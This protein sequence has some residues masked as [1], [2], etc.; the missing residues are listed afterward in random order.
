MSKTERVGRAAATECG[1][2][3]EVISLPSPASAPAGR[4]PAP[5]TP[6]TDGGRIRRPRRLAVLGVLSGA[7]R[8][9]PP[10]PATSEGT[11]ISSR[12]HLPRQPEVDVLACD[13]DLL[14]PVV[15]AARRAARAP[16]GR[17]PRASRRRRSGRRS[18]ARRAGRRRSRPRRR[19]A[20][21]AAPRA[22]ATS[23]SRCAFELVGEPITRISVAPIE[24]ISLTASCRFCVA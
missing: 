20:S 1:I 7:P 8:A 14:V 3:T 4:S 24:T 9:A 5:P 12:R 13:R 2:W 17:A 11:E 16:P 15:A 6:D 23:T 19:S 10:L 18:R 22:C 21:P